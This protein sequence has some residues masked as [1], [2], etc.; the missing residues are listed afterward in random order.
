MP[1]A[2]APTAFK[3]S[4]RS[5]VSMPSLL[6]EAL[7]FRVESNWIGETNAHDDVRLLA[8]LNDNL[9]D[10][11]GELVRHVVTL[12]DGSAGVLTNVERFV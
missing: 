2:A 7:F 10:F 11:A 6:R 8:E 3:R 9:L 12:V 4:R 1:A 5:T